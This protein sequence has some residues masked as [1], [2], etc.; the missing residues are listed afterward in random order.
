MDIVLLVLRLLVVGLL[1]AFLGAILLIL[2]RDLRQATVERQATHPESRLVVLEA[3]EGATDRLASGTAFVLQPVTSIGRSASNAVVIPDTYTSSQHALLTWRDGQ[4][5]LED[6]NSRNGTRLN[7]RL[8]EEAT[9][10]SAGD[11]IGLGR[12]KLKLEVG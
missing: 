5:W 2:W 1:Y 4:W 6:R 12:T 7:G 10:V 3:P 11:V 9:L 8:V